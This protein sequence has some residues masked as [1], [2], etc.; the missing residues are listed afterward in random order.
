MS[1]YIVDTCFHEASLYD[2]L[3]KYEHYPRFEPLSLS[4]NSL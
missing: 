3:P 2:L 4:I 1:L